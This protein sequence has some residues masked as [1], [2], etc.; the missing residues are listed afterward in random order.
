[1][2][3]PKTGC[4]AGKHKW[5]YFLS[6]TLAK[7]GLKRTCRRCLRSSIATIRWG[8]AHT[9]TERLAYKEIPPIVRAQPVDWEALGVQPN[10]R[11]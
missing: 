8:R 2:T 11:S 6:V 5:E 4:K 9:I 3:R 7:W 10:V 1:M